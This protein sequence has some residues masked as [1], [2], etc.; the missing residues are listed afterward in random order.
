MCKR[1]DVM[2]LTQIVDGPPTKD[3]IEGGGK[4]VKEPCGLVGFVAIGPDRRQ[5]L[6]DLGVNMTW[7]EYSS[8]SERWERCLMSEGV[9]ELLEDLH[10]EGDFPYHFEVAPS[11][12]ELAWLRAQAEG[13]SERPERPLH[14]FVI[15]ANA[16]ELDALALIGGTRSPRRRRKAG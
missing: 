7:A 8:D 2:S 12:G 11:R 3:F 1:L 14:D 15:G 9:A 13:A 16:E 5:Y 6:E 10:A 4:L